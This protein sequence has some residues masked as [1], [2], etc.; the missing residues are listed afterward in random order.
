M[1]QV[2]SLRFAR[3]NLCFHVLVS[4]LCQFILDVRQTLPGN[5]ER[6]LG[7]SEKLV[8]LIGEF[9]H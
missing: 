4:F 6:L 2:V 3:G 5:C 1:L 8:E 7:E 9:Y